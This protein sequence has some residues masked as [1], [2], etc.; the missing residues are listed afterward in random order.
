LALSDRRDRETVLH[1]GDAAWQELCAALEAAPEPGLYG[2]DGDQWTARDV[3]AHFAHYHEASRDALAKALAG[4]RNSWPSEGEDVINARWKAA[5]LALSLEHCRRWANESRQAHR[6]ML[7][8]LTPEQWERFG[9]KWFTDDIDG[10][11]YRG[12]MEYIRANA[13]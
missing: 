10:G 13:E 1:E 2:V 9:T 12:H 11:H 8:E 6:A 5:D 3:Y 7:F 4:D